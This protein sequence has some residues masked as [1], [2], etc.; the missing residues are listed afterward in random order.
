MAAEIATKRLILVT[1]IWQSIVKGTVKAVN[2]IF[3][4]HF[5]GRR[6][7]QR[8]ELATTILQIHSRLMEAVGRTSAEA[9]IAYFKLYEGVYEAVY[10]PD[11]GVEWITNHGSE[12]F[13]PAAVLFEP[14]GPSAPLRRGERPTSPVG[15]NLPMLSATSL[16]RH[17]MV[18]LTTNT[19]VRHTEPEVGASTLYAGVHAVPVSSDV[20]LGRTGNATVVGEDLFVRTEQ[21]LEPDSLS[22][23]PQL[24]VEQFG[25]AVVHTEAMT[26]LVQLL[27]RESLN[28]SG[29]GSAAQAK[30]MAKTRERKQRK[31]AARKAQRLTAAPMKQVFQPYRKVRKTAR[32]TQE[33]VIPEASMW[34]DD[35]WP[36]ETELMQGLYTG[37]WGGTKFIGEPEAPV[38]H[39][40]VKRRTFARKKIATGEEGD[41]DDNKPLPTKKQKSILKLM[42]S[43]FNAAGGHGPG[44]SGVNQAP[45]RKGRTPDPCRHCGEQVGAGDYKKHICDN[46]VANV[47]WCEGCAGVIA[48]V[49]TPGYWI[50]HLH[51]C[52]KMMC[53]KCKVADHY[54]V[55]CPLM[56]CNFKGC[57]KFGHT[58]MLHYFQKGACQEYLALLGEPV[59]LKSTVAPAGRLNKSKRS[60][61]VQFGEEGYDYEAWRDTELVTSNFL[62]N[63]LR[64]PHGANSSD[65]AERVTLDT[66]EPCMVFIPTEPG[67]TEFAIDRRSL[68]VWEPE[69]PVES[70]DPLIADPFLLELDD[71]MLPDW[72]QSMLCFNP[73]C[74]TV[75]M[76][77]ND[78]LSS[79][80][81][82]S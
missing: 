68:S 72:V 44:V 32:L 29:Q 31:K 9:N 33:P 1:D 20:M 24:N 15:P 41:S 74:D 37:L 16:S 11:C 69:V 63:H 17:E 10:K 18:G 6:D 71:V 55:T 73:L 35:V 59:N 3:E 58:K 19:G 60:R 25:N 49:N 48:G 65:E 53:R 43:Q 21:S 61:N 4:R 62:N 50:L 26:P 40:V 34:P 22:A 28:G 45:L 27:C 54:W 56:V 38:T 57:H 12:Y 77:E 78:A 75:D 51:L 13:S 70:V 47:F 23:A 2:G 79:S 76:K 30:K 66:L 14:L 67:I 42:A 5:T 36:M 80:V 64:V 81:D 82:W 46:K 52:P 39:N 8:A 7:T